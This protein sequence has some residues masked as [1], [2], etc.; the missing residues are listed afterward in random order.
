MLKTIND[1]MFSIRHLNEKEILFFITED[2]KKHDIQDMFA[3]A[4]LEDEIEF[5]IK[6]KDKELNYKTTVKS[7]KRDY[8]EVKTYDKGEVKL[9]A[10]DF[11]LIE[12]Q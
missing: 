3:D 5:N 4:N 8:R 6:Y 7:V 10:L 2:D 11:E 12:K 1:I 9:L